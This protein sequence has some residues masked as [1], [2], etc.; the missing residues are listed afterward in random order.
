MLGAVGRGKARHSS[1]ARW[2]WAS[3]GGAGQRKVRHNSTAQRGRAELGRAWLCKAA[4]GIVA[5]LGT[6]RL[7]RAGSGL[8]TQCKATVVLEVPVL[9]VLI[10][11]RSKVTPITN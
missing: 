1:V 9:L 10:K 5:G 4:Q 11:A 7:G 2:G 3:R 8:V 6:V